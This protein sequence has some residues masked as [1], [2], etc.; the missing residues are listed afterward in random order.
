M[1]KKLSLICFLLLCVAGLKAQTTYCYHRYKHYDKN[2]IPQTVDSYEYLT[3]YGD[4]LYPSE[5]DGGYRK[6]VYDGKPL[7]QL[8]RY[9]KKVNGCL[10]YSSWNEKAN[11]YDDEIINPVGGTHYSYYL[12]SVDK[13]EVNH[14]FK[15]WYGS[16][17]KEY[18]APYTIC[19]KLCPFEDCGKTNEP[20][21]KH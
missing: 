15:G 18:I 17:G 10:L 16:D 5:K 14:I 19:L 21:M 12:V 13:S 2:D 9:K 8:Y 6:S 3:F 1:A 7:K 4:W 11:N 20:I